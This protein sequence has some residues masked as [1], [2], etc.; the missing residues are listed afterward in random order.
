MPREIVRDFRRNNALLFI[1]GSPGWATEEES[2]FCLSAQG[3]VTI[4]EEVIVLRLG[5]PHPGSTLVLIT[6]LCFGADVF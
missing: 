3:E 5:D 6:H 2:G 4:W 1:A